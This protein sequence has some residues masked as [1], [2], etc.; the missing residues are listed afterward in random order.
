[1]LMTGMDILLFLALAISAFL[2]YSRGFVREILAIGTWVLAAL[3]T[4][5]GAQMLA[6]H[7]A[8]AFGTS[9]SV[10]SI[11][12][13]VIIFV[14]SIFIASFIVKKISNKLHATD[15]KSADQALGFVFGLVRGVL[16]TSAVYLFILWLIPQE[17]ERPNWFITARSRPI[18][19]QGAVLLDAL[20]IP[21]GL[22]VLKEDNK[23]ATDPKLNEK[24]Y[25]NLL[26]P[27]I[28]QEEVFKEKDLDVGYTNSE[29]EDLERQLRQIQEMER[30]LK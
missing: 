16:V 5:I 29:R 20:F 4:K 15:F 10:G 18:L 23:F 28:R 13:Y 14:I 25:Q 27:G 22:D 19:R 7:M 1:M 3:F 2:A 11:I 8:E 17:T 12:A 21:S 24:T 26:K 9:E 6:P 30:T